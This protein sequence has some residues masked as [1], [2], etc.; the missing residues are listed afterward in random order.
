[1]FQSPAQPSVWETCSS[2]IFSVYSFITPT[3]L[4]VFCL[5]LVLLLHNKQTTSMRSCSF[6]HTLSPPP[7]TNIS[8]HIHFLLLRY[9]IPPSPPRSTIINNNYHVQESVWSFNMDAHHV[10]LRQ[11]AE[12]KVSENYEG[13]VEKM[14]VETRVKKT[15]SGWKVGRRGQEDGDPHIWR[16]SEDQ[17]YRSLKIIQGSRNWW[18]YLY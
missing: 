12:G 1:M 7:L 15:R 11:R 3:L 16:I 14:L 13:R 4:Y 6:T 10:P 5:D 17:T 9:H 18:D 8:D 2:L